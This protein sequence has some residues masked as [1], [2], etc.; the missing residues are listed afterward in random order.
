MPAALAR[1]PFFFLAA[2]SLCLIGAAHANTFTRLYSFEGPRNND[3]EYPLSLIEDGA[4]NLY[5]ITLQG[6][7][8][9][10]HHPLGFGTVFK[11]AA[12]GTETV[13]HEFSKDETPNGGLVIDSAGNLYGTAD[14]LIFEL[15]SDGT[16]ST[17]FQFS[18]TD[19]ADPFGP[20]Y[21]DTQGLLY[22]P[23]EGGGT[24]N[25]GVIFRINGDGTETVL[26]A[27]GG[28]SDGSYPGPVI[29]DGSGNLY[30]TTAEGGGATGCG[31]YGCGTVFKIAADGTYSVLYAF[32][33]GSDGEYPLSPL[34]MDGQGNLIGVTTAGGGATSCDHGCG[35]I[36]TLSPD[37]TEQVLYRFQGGSDGSAPDTLVADRKGNLYGATLDGGEMTACAEFGCGTL[38]I[39]STAGSKKIIHTFTGTHV[40]GGEPSGLLWNGA[41]Y[42]YGIAAAGGVHPA[43]C[44]DGCGTIFKVTQ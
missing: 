23:T 29:A 25:K 26:H 28:G 31:S 11:F 39:F 16:Y 33:G 15:A 4:G 18:T 37:G 14:N 30:G 19:G 24:Y 10:Y 9:D 22:G 35:T 36:F 41:G 27:F 43:E 20:L 8:Y 34:L 3:G 40:D 1:I 21:R 38:F 12:D 5:G 17:V 32:Q 42:L 7:S 2:A 6:G 13:L 44:P